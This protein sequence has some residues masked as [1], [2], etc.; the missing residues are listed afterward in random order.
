MQAQKFAVRHT[1]SS[2][3]H[4]LWDCEI[5]RRIDDPDGFEDQRIGFPDV[6]RHVED[7]S[8]PVVCEIVKL[9]G[10]ECNYN[11]SALGLVGG[12]LHALRA[13]PA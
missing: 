5:R 1:Q 4:C 6:T 10:R 3:S 12:D 8:T 9:F 2:R 7:V 11:T 13:K